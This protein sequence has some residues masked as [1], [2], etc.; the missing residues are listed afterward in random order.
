MLPLAWPL[1][2]AQ[3]SRGGLE[4]RAA[5]TQTTLLVI[6]WDPAP[7]T[8]TN[9]HQQYRRHLSD[10]CP[11]SPLNEH[12]QNNNTAGCKEHNLQD[13]LRRPNKTHDASSCLFRRAAQPQTARGGVPDLCVSWLLT[14]LS[15]V[16]CVSLYLPAASGNK[17]LHLSLHSTAVVQSLLQDPQSHQSS[18]THSRTFLLSSPL[19]PSSFV[20][21]AFGIAFPPF[22]SGLFPSFP[23]IRLFSSS[24]P[25]SKRTHDDTS[26]QLSPPPQHPQP[27]PPPTTCRRRRSDLA[28]PIQ[29]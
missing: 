8:S 6:S 13:C 16:G 20:V 24:S 29:R 27:Q 9:Q 4:F 22:L 5:S 1:A 11:I 18:S 21:I 7:R 2:R 17:K 25:S 28:L 15:A 3:R 10:V 23:G 14:C 19:T 26:Q 12:I